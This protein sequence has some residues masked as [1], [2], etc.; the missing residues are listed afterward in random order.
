M[1][2]SFKWLRELVDLPPEVTPK[3][4]A[5]KLTFAGLE[6]EAV[7]DQ[8][9]ELAGVVVARITSKE[10]H[11]DADKLS[12]CVVDAGG[13]L[14]PVVCGAQNH[15][16]G[17]LAV[18]AKVGAK[19]PNGVEIKATK[20]RGA[21]S[22][23][24]LCSFQE[25]GLEGDSSG[26]I[27]LDPT[28]YGDVAPGAKAASA[29]GRDDV[30]LEIAVTPNRPDALSHVGVAREV[31]ALLGARSKVQRP[32]CAE[33]AGPVDDVVQVEIKDLEGCPRYACR[34][35]EDVK[36]GPSPDWLV[37]RLAACGV[38]SINN[39]V[40]VTN[41]VMMERGIPLH[42]FDL[43]RLAKARERASVIVRRAEAGE[44]IR[45]LDDKV[46][47]L[48]EG[49]LV[50][51]DPNGP[52]AV[53]GVMGG[54]DSEVRE[55]STRVLLEAAC[56]APVRV[57]RTARRLGIHSEAS[58]RFERGTDPNGVRLSLDRAASLLAELAGG[59]VCRGVVDVYPRKIE[60]AVVPL[61]P[62]RTADF[63][64]LSPKIVSETAC[65][66][67]LLSIGLEV[68][69]REGEAV[70]FRVPTF[71]PDLTREVDLIEEIARLLGYDQVPATLPA[72][73]GESRGLYDER[74]VS[75]EAKARAALEAAGFTEAIN[76]A[77]ASPA[78]Q[79]PFDG[80]APERRI[81]IKNPLGEDMSLLRRS[82]LPGLLS[83]AALNARR[84]HSSVRL[85]EAATIFDGRNLAG[86]RPSLDGAGPRGGDAWA[87]ERP[88][89]AAVALGEIGARAF[90]RRPTEVDFYDMK[91]VCESILERVGVDVDLVSG[92][93]SFTPA[94]KGAAYLH[95]RARAEVKVS[96]EVVGVIGEIHPDVLVHFDMKGPVMAFELCTDRLAQVAPPRAVSE[97]PPRFPAVRRDFALVLD[98][99]VAAG[100]LCRMLA[101]HESVRGLVED[102]EIFDIYRGEHVPDGKKSV[103][104]SLTLRAPDRTLTDDE[105]AGMADALV[106]AAKAR[107][108]AAI[109]A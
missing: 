60:E 105:V 79:A 38:R 62:K 10:K 73:T 42:A 12:V 17:D 4:V 72:R 78:L 45:T 48:E 87:C 77:F 36:V 11:P 31:T 104:L 8:A 101:Q 51:A 55:S 91:G 109:R 90:D 1:R 103:A 26:I 63:L 50:I 21:T 59:V 53:A 80:D 40:D 66:K 16:A 43:D 84:G 74:R 61:R 32:A 96:D 82:L 37:Q 99:Q 30:I 15:N 92:Q 64:G 22:E 68:A 107:Y 49:D 39:V 25:L 46:R 35:V 57:R 2:V 94:D 75:V 76:L 19:L 83:N 95:P 3:D 52:I 27:I 97:P 47:D 108:G 33:R 14:V 70:R 41:L 88:M 28:L 20:I 93:V 13:E 98:E 65:S 24:M 54:A 106:G 7:H 86:E 102:V 85:Y 9:A 100:E 71:R 89:L 5:T 34:V 23:G 81:T 18:L 58:H 44:K 67:I 69:G 29:L 56:F 6:V